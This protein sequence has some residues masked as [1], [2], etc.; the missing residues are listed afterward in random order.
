MSVRCWQML[1]L[2]AAL[3]SQPA[4]SHQIKG[5]ETEAVEG[6]RLLHRPERNE[7]APDPRL[8]HEGDRRRGRRRAQA[9]QRGHRLEHVAQ[10][11]RVND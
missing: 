9:A 4:L 6:A 7:Q 10:R 1:V 5:L 3:V 11:T 2:L 8:A